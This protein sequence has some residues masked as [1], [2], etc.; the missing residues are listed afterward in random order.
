M[1]SFLSVRELFLSRHKNGSSF[2]LHVPELDLYS[3]QTLA[4]VGQSGCGKS[5]LT[6]ILALILK[7]DRAEKFVMRDGSLEKDL[8]AVFRKSTKNTALLPENWS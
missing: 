1:M 5:T 7:P 6:D 2:T 8:C 4:V 3:G